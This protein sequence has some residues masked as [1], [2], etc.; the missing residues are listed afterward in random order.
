MPP[1]VSGKTAASLASGQAKSHTRK[2]SANPQEIASSAVRIRKDSCIATPSTQ[3]KTKIC[4]RLETA[5]IARR[6]CAKRLRK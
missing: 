5:R 3:A 2:G 4:G 6:K 1:C